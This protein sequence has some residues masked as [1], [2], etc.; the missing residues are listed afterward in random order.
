MAHR[1]GDGDC[2]AEEDREEDDEGESEEA[3][4]VQ[5]IEHREGGFK[6]TD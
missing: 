1:E 4:T 6:L 3:P 5:A 2:H